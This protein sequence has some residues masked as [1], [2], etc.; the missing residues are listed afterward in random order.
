MCLMVLKSFKVYYT[1]LLCNSKKRKFKSFFME[2]HGKSGSGKRKNQQ[3][4]L[5]NE[6]AK[7]CQKISTFLRPRV[8]EV[9]PCSS[10][11][12]LHLK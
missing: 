3:Q 9:D 10:R 8:A 1:D 6:S 5:R 12:W 7:N 2:K 4:S 11:K